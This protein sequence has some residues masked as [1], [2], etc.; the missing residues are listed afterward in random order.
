MAHDIAMTHHE[1]F[2]GRGYPY[3]LKG[4]EIPL[5]GRITA[6][7]DV[8]DAL[9]TR[10]VYKP[11]IAH[12]ATRKIIL[13][14]RGKHFDPDVIQAFLNREEEFVAVNERFDGNSLSSEEPVMFLGAPGRAHAPG[15]STVGV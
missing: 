9:T 3:G 2:D 14:G 15:V 4:D 12:E 1:H 13:E 7:A 10:R 6:L 11:K 5:C 8:Y